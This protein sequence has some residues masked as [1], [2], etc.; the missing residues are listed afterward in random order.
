M[1]SLFTD[2]Q[3]AIDDS[4]KYSVSPDLQ[5]IKDEYGLAMVQANWAAVFI[6]TGIEELNNGDTQDATSNI[7]QAT[8]NMESFGQH[9]QKMNKMLDAYK[10]SKYK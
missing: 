3:Q 5:D 9:V 1:K 7:E 6:N 8:E 2:S 10:I 4:D